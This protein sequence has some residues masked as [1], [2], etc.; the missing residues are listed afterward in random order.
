MYACN[1]PNLVTGS[2]FLGGCKC[3]CNS[4]CHD[5]DKLSDFHQMNGNLKKK[6]KNRSEFEKN[7]K[8][9]TNKLNR[10]P[11]F[12]DEGKGCINKQTKHHNNSIHPFI[13]T[14]TTVPHN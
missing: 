10:F 7:I 3:M 11:S 8:I 2:L 5:N 9:K 12:C 1:N 14:T 4:S 13:T 6:K